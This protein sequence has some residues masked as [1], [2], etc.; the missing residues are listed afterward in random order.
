LLIPASSYQGYCLQY[1]EDALI[2]K[3]DYKGAT[4]YWDWTIGNV[5]PLARLGSPS[6][7]WLNPS[8]SI[9]TRKTFNSPFFDNTSSGVGSWGDPTNDY[10][11]YTGR[12]KDQIRACPKPSPH[13]EELLAFPVL[14][15]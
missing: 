10:L 7:R 14:Q 13:Q 11:I 5:A 4:S 12:F 1:F 15:P 2:Q 6:F 9:Q 3:C 8:I